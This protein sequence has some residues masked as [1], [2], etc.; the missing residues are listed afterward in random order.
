MTFPSENQIKDTKEYIL[1]TARKLFSDFSYLEVSMED[2]AKKLNITK[3]AIYYHFKNKTEI[4]LKVLERVF[5]D[6]H[7]IILEASKEK[8]L[9][10]R[11]FKLI[12]KYLEFGSKEKNLVKILMINL[13]IFDKK[14]VDLIFQ[15]RKKTID[16]VQSLIESKITKKKLKEKLDTKTLAS[17][18][19]AMLDGTILEYSFFNKKIDSEKI[20][21]QI[22]AVLF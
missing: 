12:K 16:L 18:L 7:S 2:I 19:V 13:S 5:N 22:I 15:L 3:P 10:K 20:A 1:D 4:Y 17:L 14:I 8:T 21:S 11:L 9:K 6:L